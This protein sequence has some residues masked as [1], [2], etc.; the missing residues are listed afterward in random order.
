[1]PS[2]CIKN[3]DSRTCQSDSKEI[4]FFTFPKEATIRQ[5]W[6]NACGENENFKVESGKLL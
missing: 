3:C 4:N 6:L 1:M 2:C 5:Q